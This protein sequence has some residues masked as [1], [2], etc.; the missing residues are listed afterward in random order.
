MKKNAGLLT[1]KM[2][3][4]LSLILD[5]GAFPAGANLSPMVYAWGLVGG[6]SIRKLAVSCMTETTETHPLIQSFAP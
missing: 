1:L 3:K 4:R 2:R 6:G 5:G